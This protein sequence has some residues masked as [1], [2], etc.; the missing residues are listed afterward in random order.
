MENDT[1]F[2]CHTHCATIISALHYLPLSAILLLAFT[3]RDFLDLAPSRAGWQT[4]VLPLVEGLE[5]PL[6]VMP[7]SI[8]PGPSL[9]NY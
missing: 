7:L 8:L 5:S 9:E 2:S 4:T 6:A 1:Q 3:V